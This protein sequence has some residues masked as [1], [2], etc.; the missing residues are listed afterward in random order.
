MKR[1]QAQRNDTSINEFVIKRDEIE[2]KIRTFNKS[3][4][5]KAHNSKI[6]KHKVC[7]EIRNDSVRDRILNGTLCREECDNENVYEF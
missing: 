2:E 1:L 6:C 7:K 4:F 5:K 3:H